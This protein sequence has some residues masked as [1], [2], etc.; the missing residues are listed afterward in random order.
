MR[1]A[2]EIK[3]EESTKWNKEK[4]IE[5]LKKPWRW[6]DQAYWLLRHKIWQVIGDIPHNIYS[7]VHR[8]IYGWAP[9]DVWSFDY[10]ISVVIKDGLTHLKKKGM[11]YPSDITKAKWDKTLDKMIYTFDLCE[12]IANGDVHYMNSHR[13]SVPNYKKT[14]KLLDGINKDFKTKN[15][16]MTRKESIRFELG[17]K[18]L[19]E[20]FFHLWD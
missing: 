10:Y 13:F 16:I 2:D 7:F 9:C 12:K 18:L 8:G 1:D 15:R 20:Y 5:S 14:K 4:Y 11:S 6:Y 3:V 17:F 19:E